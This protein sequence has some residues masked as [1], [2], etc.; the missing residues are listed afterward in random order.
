M[1]WMSLRN[2]FNRLLGRGRAEAVDSSTLEIMRAYGAVMQQ[3]AA[4]QT[5]LADS[6]ELPYAKEAIKAAIVDTMQSTSDS[7]TRE[8]LK[9][10]YVYL[11]NWQ[12]GFTQAEQQT[13][14]PVMDEEQDPLEMADQAL[15]GRPKYEGWQAKVKEEQ[16][17][18]QQE[19]EQ[20]GL[21]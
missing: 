8:M 7:D 3:Q 4:G 2:L 12:A 6:S 10:G 5:G 11:A 16:Q 21:W 17:A 15:E 13:E 20:L 9:A 18:L 1:G 19:L 14:L